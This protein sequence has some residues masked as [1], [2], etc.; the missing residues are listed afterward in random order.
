MIAAMGTLSVS[1]IEIISALSKVINVEVL[2][3]NPSPYL[4]NEW[5]KQNS[6]V[7]VSLGAAPSR[8]DDLHVLPESDVLVFQFVLSEFI[9][10]DCS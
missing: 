2:C 6:L 10:I 8:N 7:N 3:V 5:A 1:A 4:S 9:P